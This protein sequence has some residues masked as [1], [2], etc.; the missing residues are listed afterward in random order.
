[1]FSDFTPRGD[2]PRGNQE[3]GHGNAALLPPAQLI[4]HIYLQIQDSSSSTYQLRRVVAEPLVQPDKS[5]EK[6]IAPTTIRPT[7]RRPPPSPPKLTINDA[8][9]EKNEEDGEESVREDVN[10][11][12]PKASSGLTVLLIVASSDRAEY[13]QKCLS[14]VNKYHPRLGEVCPVKVD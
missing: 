8:I 5:L 3:R 7:E 1:M 10:Q 4:F 6:E 14:Y 12:I 13:L 2:I 11:F 9:E